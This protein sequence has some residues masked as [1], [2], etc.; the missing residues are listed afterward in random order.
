[1]SDPLCVCGDRWHKVLRAKAEQILAE[2][3]SADFEFL[4]GVKIKE[5]R[6]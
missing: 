6:R 2:M 3:T 4:N 5:S 1:M